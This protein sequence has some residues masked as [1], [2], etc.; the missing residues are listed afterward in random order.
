M[1]V[2]NTR[3]FAMAFSIRMHQSSR[4]LGFA[5]IG[6]PSFVGILS[7]IVT[8]FHFCS[9][10]SKMRI[11]YFPRFEYSFVTYLPGRGFGCQGWAS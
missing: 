9:S 5:K 8:R 4:S 11:M 2:H 7:S 3:T 10:P 6:L 1:E